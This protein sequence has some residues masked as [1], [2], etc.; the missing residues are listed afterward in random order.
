MTKRLA[1]MCFMAVFLIALGLLLLAAACSTFPK[2]ELRVTKT[3][4]TTLYNSVTGIG[5]GAW[6][7]G[8]WVLL[9]RWY[10]KIQLNAP[11]A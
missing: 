2:D 10:R 8:R 7:R 3:E 5:Y 9:S 6:E 4:I 11:S 1:T